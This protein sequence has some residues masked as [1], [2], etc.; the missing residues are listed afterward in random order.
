MRP[1]PSRAAQLGKYRA[2]LLEL[3]PHQAAEELGVAE[4][5]TAQ[6]AH[7]VGYF[8]RAGMAREAASQARAAVR[9]SRLVRVAREVCEAQ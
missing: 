9:R 2:R 5:I 8:H 7:S 1:R 4:H 3:E 6:A